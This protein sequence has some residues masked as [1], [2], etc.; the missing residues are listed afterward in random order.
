MEKRLC[1]A[2]YFAY[3]DYGTVT[4]LALGVHTSG[5]GWKV[6][7]EQKPIDIFPPEFSLFH[8]VVSPSV[9]P[10]TKYKAEVEFQSPEQ[11]KIVKVQDACGT[12]EVGVQQMQ[13][14]HGWYD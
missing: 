11:V 12:H 8:E 2:I 1:R 13:K 3:Q 10:I 9:E 14:G 5:S 7:F 6:F 4:V